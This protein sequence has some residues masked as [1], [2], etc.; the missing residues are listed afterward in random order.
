MC[1]EISINILMK[2]QKQKQA[3]KQ[4]HDVIFAHS[5]ENEFYTHTLRCTP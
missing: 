3:D 4:I 5:Y 1:L 2:K